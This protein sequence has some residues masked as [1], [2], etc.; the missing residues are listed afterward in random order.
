MN[1][2]T[3]VITISGLVGLIQISIDYPEEFIRAPNFVVRGLA[4]IAHPHQRFNPNIN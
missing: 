2:R 3:Q 4:L 1:R